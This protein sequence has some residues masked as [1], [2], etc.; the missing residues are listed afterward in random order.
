MGGCGSDVEPTFNNLYDIEVKKINGET[1]TLGQY[2]GKVLLIVNTASKCGFTKQ[3][4]PLEA[5][6]QKY[7][8]RGFEI[9]GF[10]SNDFLHQD[11][12]TNTEILD[13]CQVNYGVTFQMFEKICVKG[14]EQHQLYAFLTSE[15]TNPRFSGKISWNFNKFLIA[16]NGA[17][18]GKFG[19]MTSPE[20]KK[21]VKAVEDAIG[22]QS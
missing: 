9:L 11:P 14:P 7:R 3:F 22:P 6:Y 2:Q 15:K 10:P 4:A 17:I 5:L 19:S 8:S 16:R 1:T 12:G 13:F 20:D 18:V 21:F